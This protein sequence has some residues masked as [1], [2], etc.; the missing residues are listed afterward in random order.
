[1]RPFIE[2]WLGRHLPKQYCAFKGTR[3][4]IE[5]TMTRAVDA[6]GSEK[7]VTVIGSGHWR[8]LDEPRRLEIPGR[9][10]EQP[11]NRETGPGLFLGLSRVMASDPEALVAVLPSDHYVSSRRRLA[12]HLRRAFALAGRLS[13]SIVLL[14]VRPDRPETDYGWIE[15][16]GPC[17]DL[18][19]PA[20]PVAR[21]HEKPHPQAAENMMRWG[22]L[23]NTMVMVG[24][25]RAFWELG[26]R[27][28]PAM[29]ERFEAL[30]AS[31]AQARGAGEE[32]PELLAE[33]YRGMPA[34]NFSKDLL[35]KEPGACVS[36]PLEGLE[37]CDWGRPE[38]VLETLSKL[39]QT[40]AFPAGLIPAPRG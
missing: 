19:W 36:L 10:V 25:V 12:T 7:I 31:L 14:G 33:L 24:R 2:S 40:P 32:D 35:E 8:H 26:K 11:E 13:E 4:M 29:M 30:R 22:F 15:T 3:T 17:W 1:M 6:V 39:G 38:R 5:H 28:H 21:F 23:W 16:G 18:P 27:N 37:W 34:V 20:R 9:I